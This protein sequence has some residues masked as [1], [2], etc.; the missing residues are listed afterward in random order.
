M[1]RPGRHTSSLRR[2]IAQ[3]MHWTGI[4][5]L[6]VETATESMALTNEK[7]MTKQTQSV[8]KHH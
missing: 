1:C 6:K 4:D 2:I 5:I 3:R 8:I 7:S